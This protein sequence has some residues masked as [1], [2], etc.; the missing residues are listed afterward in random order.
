MAVAGCKSVQPVIVEHVKHDSIYVQQIRQD[1]I[2]IHD[3]VFMDRSKDTVTI[4]KYHTDYRYRFLHDTVAVTKVDS[5][6]YAVEVVKEVRKPNG[7]DKFCH[8]ITAIAIVALLLFVAY[9]LI[10]LYLRR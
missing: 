10:K 7:W 1:S 4:Y 6:P 9:K 5:I 3:S 2:Y 8:W